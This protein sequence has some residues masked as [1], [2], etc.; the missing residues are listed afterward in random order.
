[1]LC[2]GDAVV[3]ERWTEDRTKLHLHVIKGK[4]QDLLA[5]PSSITKI[6]AKRAARPAQRTKH[7]KASNGPT[8]KQTSGQGYSPIRGTSGAL[9]ALHDAALLCANTGTASGQLERTEGC[10]SNLEAPSKGHGVSAAAVAAA[11]AAA[12]RLD[13]SRL[14]QAVRSASHHHMLSQSRNRDR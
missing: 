13:G 14:T 12:L 6:K 1:M 8:A 2:I 11:D 9:E 5:A 3:L 7:G 4:S 10:D